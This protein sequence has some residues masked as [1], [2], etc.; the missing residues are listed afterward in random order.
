MTKELKESHK[1][2]ESKQQEEWSDMRPDSQG[3]QPHRVFQAT[4]E[5]RSKSSVNP[6]KGFMLV[7]FKKTTYTRGAK[8]VFTRG[9]ICLAVA[10]KGP[11]GILGLYKCNYSLTRV[12]ELGAAGQKQG[13]RLDKT[14]WRARFGLCAL[15][16]PLCS[17]DIGTGMS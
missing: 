2:L 17:R 3:G 14:R 7:C 15:C 8:L 4:Y 12:K 5:I 11:N 9:H 16:L 10:F 6:I 13:A 1:V